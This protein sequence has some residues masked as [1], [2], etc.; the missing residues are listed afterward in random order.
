MRVAKWGVSVWSFENQASTSTSTHKERTSLSLS[1]SLSLSIYIYIYIY[2]FFF[3]KM[4]S[5]VNNLPLFRHPILQP[6]ISSCVTFSSQKGRM[7]IVHLKK[8]LLM[9]LIINFTP[10]LAKVC[11]HP[12]LQLP[13][14]LTF[15]A[16]V[17][18]LVSHYVS[19][20]HRITWINYNFD[21][22]ISN[23]IA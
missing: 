9:T 12:I 8:T 18:H 7:V 22:L 20:L 11:R 14:N 5:I 16:F 13:F 1:L 10:S 2:F 4:K 17:L 15:I 19:P 6:S 23:C 3:N 21:S